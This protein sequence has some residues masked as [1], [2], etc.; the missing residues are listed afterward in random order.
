MP[1]V[2]NARLPLA[3]LL[4]LGAS[5][6]PDRSADESQPNA[7]VAPHVLLIVIDTLSAGH[8]GCYG[9]PRP[10]SPN[11]DALA[12]GGVLFEQASANAPWTQPS[13]MALITGVHAAAHVEPLRAAPGEI[14]EQNRIHPD[15]VT[16]A[17]HF[18][19]AGYDTAGFADIYWLDAAFGF[20]DG[21]DVYDLS[22]NERGLADREGGIAHVASRYLEWLD[23][24]NDPS[25][26]SFTFLHAFDV[27]GP[28]LADAAW[29][30][31]VAAVASGYDLPERLPASGMAAA[32]H[33]I[34][35]YVTGS[36]VFPGGPPEEVDPAPYLDAYD[37]GIAEVDATLGRLFAEL[38]RRGQLDDTL[39]VVTADHGESIELNGRYFGHGSVSQEILHVPLIVKLPTGPPF[40]AP[41]PAQ[42]GQ[43]QRVD[44][45]VQL[46]DLL[47][48]LL[49]L[50]GLAPPQLPTDGR[51]LKPLLAGGSLQTVPL[52]ASQGLFT[53]ASLRLGDWRLSR[54]L[55]RGGDAA[56]RMTFFGLDDA[57]LA[58]HLPEIHNRP[59]TAARMA[60]IQ[61]RLGGLEALE[62]LLATRQPNSELRL[63]NLSTDPREQVNLIESRPD[64][65]EELN[66]LLLRQ[67]LAALEDRIVDEVVAPIELDD[68]S[69]EALQAVGYLEDR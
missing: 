16:L 44:T 68:A 11:L 3:A 52:F 7:S 19:A 61:A 36:F 55:L 23:G 34:S 53:Q 9:Y 54:Y 10:T 8:L 43:P 25:A 46:I 27:H 51:T 49:D 67:Y 38:E 4:A 57:W 33:S 14:N 45:P 39:V 32:F 29:R 6:S 65:A 48:T 1:D 12:A 35:A 24:R 58:E 30:E 63:Y 5:C 64:K 26:P 31:R 37:A 66:E 17:E 13:L 59:L 20:G 62:A 28:Y 40:D 22:A 42:T 47:P 60:A 56:A 21:F 2:C 18:S 41:W 69:I 15:R 50:S